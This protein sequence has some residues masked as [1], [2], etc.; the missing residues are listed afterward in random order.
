M[1]ALDFATQAQQMKE[2]GSQLASYAWGAANVILIIGAHA[3]R[4]QA[5]GM[6]GFRRFNSGSAC[7]QGRM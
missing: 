7:R 4:E 5:S 3:R 1:F 6:R 2:I